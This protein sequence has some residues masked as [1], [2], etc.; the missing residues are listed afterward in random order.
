MLKI[1]CFPLSLLLSTS[2]FVHDSFLSFFS[3]ISNRP[4]PFLQ[5]H[6]TPDSVCLSLTSR[7]ITFVPKVVQ[8]GSK[9]HKS[10]TFSYHIWPKLLKSDL[11]KHSPGLSHLGLIW[12][13]FVSHLTACRSD[14]SIRP[15]FGLTTIRPSS[16]LS[17]LT[18][19]VYRLVLDQIKT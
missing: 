10:W 5:E 9:W 14:N 17:R 18:T 15:L 16:P 4:T 13:F 7:Y 1:I 6:S 12:P 3:T 19:T 8:D 2:C 11:K